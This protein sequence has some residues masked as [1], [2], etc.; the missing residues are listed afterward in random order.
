MDD[1]NDSPSRPGRPRRAS[2]ELRHKT[3]KLRRLHVAPRA[4]VVTAELEGRAPRPTPIA[5]FRRRLFGAPDLTGMRVL[6]VEG[7]EE[8]AALLSMRF[9]SCGAVVS[10]ART[11]AEATL[12]LVAGRWDVLIADIG[13][14]EGEGY[15]LARIARALPLPPTC[16]AL[17]KSGNHDDIDE[18]RRAGFRLHVR[19]PCDPSVLIHIAERLRVDTME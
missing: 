4:V 16:I 10:S 13:L 5:S 15:S 3:M 8:L 11:C 6:T 7:D 12:T 2:A 17:S 14:P 19:K 1:S 9:A 18:A